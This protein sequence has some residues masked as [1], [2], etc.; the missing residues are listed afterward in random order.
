MAAFPM[1]GAAN[2]WLF[3]QDL[4]RSNPVGYWFSFGTFEVL[5]LIAIRMSMSRFRSPHRNYVEI[6]PTELS[7]V[8]GGKKKPIRRE[9]VL[10]FRIKRGRSRLEGIFLGFQWA[11]TA[12]HVEVILRKPIWLSY[13]GL[14]GQWKADFVPIEVPDLDPFKEA[15]GEWLALT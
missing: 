1:L 3:R 12:E 10:S 13:L 15:L 8:W 7:V 14:T 4:D 9:D 5:W 6:L 2:V 11:P